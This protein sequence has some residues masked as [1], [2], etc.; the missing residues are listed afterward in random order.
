MSGIDYMY[1]IM[2]FV[3]I[4]HLKSNWEKN[5]INIF[6]GEICITNDLR[7]LCENMLL[8][9]SFCDVTESCDVEKACF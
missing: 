1:V 2:V 6:I 9:A 4:D 7:I 8:T 3:I 5:L